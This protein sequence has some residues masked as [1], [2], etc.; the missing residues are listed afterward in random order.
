MHNANAR[1]DLPSAINLRRFDLSFPPPR[2]I[3]HSAFSLFAE[4]LAVLATLLPALAR[5][6]TKHSFEPLHNSSM[7]GQV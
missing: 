7:S 1:K 5:L 6:N 4:T 3:T 2:K